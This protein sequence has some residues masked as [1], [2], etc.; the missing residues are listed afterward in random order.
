MFVRSG[1]RPR[2]HHWWLLAQHPSRRA[3][4]GSFPRQ[5]SSGQRVSHPPSRVVY[6]KVLSWTIGIGKDILLDIHSDIDTPP[7][8]TV[9][10]WSWWRVIVSEFSWKEKHLAMKKPI[11]KKHKQ[12]LKHWKTH[13]PRRLE[14]ASD[15]GSFQVGRHTSFHSPQ[16]ISNSKQATTIQ[17][18][19]RGS[20]LFWGVNRQNLLLSSLQNSFRED[21]NCRLPLSQW[22]PSTVLDP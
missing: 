13:Q 5:G 6:G 3:A 18:K 4:R 7:T 10:R 17:W 1:R 11:L 15:L 22:C 20:Q 2:D 19:S 12:Y 9:S 8:K 21:H 16:V 14:R